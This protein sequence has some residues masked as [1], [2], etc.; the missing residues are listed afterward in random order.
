MNSTAIRHTESVRWTATPD[1]RGRRVQLIARRS[2]QSTLAQDDYS[3]Q[4]LTKGPLDTVGKPLQEAI[5]QGKNSTMGRR[6]ADSLTCGAEPRR[7]IRSPCSHQATAAPASALHSQLST[8]CLCSCPLQPEQGASRAISRLSSHSGQDVRFLYETTKSFSWRCES[9]HS[10][11]AGAIAQS[12]FI[13]VLPSR[14]FYA[15][16][17]TSSFPRVPD[18]SDGSNRHTTFSEIRSQCKAIDMCVTSILIHNKARD[19]R[20]TAQSRA[21]SCLAIQ[22]RYWTEELLPRRDVLQV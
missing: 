1:G 19:M 17:C 9:Y 20:R 21:D 7:Y 8:R 15:S 12:L 6:E 3:K 5:A 18:S 16:S 4:K 14:D 10:K 11:L 2:L 13:P 22:R